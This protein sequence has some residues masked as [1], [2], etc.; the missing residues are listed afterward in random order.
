MTTA[1]RRRSSL[2]TYSTIEPMVEMQITRQVANRLFN[3]T[4]S[5]F[6]AVFLEG[7]IDGDGRRSSLPAYRTIEPMVEMQI[8][9]Q[10]QNRLFNMRVSN[11]MAVL[12]EGLVGSSREI[13]QGLCQPA[14]WLPKRIPMPFA[15]FDV[16]A[17]GCPRTPPF[18]GRTVGG[19][20]RTA[21]IGPGALRC[22]CLASPA[23][24]GAGPAS[25]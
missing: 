23:A 8:T 13:W 4:A 12:R 16:A 20:H 7:D 14:P 25:G 24:W 15:R 19:G 11:F 10:A 2:R 22:G 1:M 17:A 21:G 3:M 9:R 6:M 5:N 18:Q